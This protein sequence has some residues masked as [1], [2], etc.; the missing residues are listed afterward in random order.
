[1]LQVIQNYK[2]GK[3]TVDEVPDPVL[4]PGGIIVRNHFSL[5]S[6]GT[7]RTT[8][9]TAQK[10]LAGKAKSR[11]DLVKQVVGVARRDGVASTIKLVKNKLDTSVPMGYSCAGEVIAVATD[12]DE[13]AIGDMVA[14]AGQGYASHAEIIYVPRNLAA[15]IPNGVKAE[16]AA[17]TT[18]GAIAMQSVR[19]AEIVLGEHVAVIGLGLLGLLTAQ[20]LKA[21]SCKVLGIDIKPEACTLARKLGVEHTVSSDSDLVPFVEKATH[22]FGVDKVII[23]AASSNNEPILTAGSIVREK[24]KVVI[25]GG[26]PADIPRSPFYEKEVDICFSRSYGPGRYDSTYEERGIDYPYGYVRWTENRNMQTFLDLLADGKIKFDKIITHKFQIG[27]AKEAYDMIT[28]KSKAKENYIGILLKYDSSRRK[29][30]IVKTSTPRSKSEGA[31]AVGFIGAGNFA[32][33]YLLPAVQANKDANLLGVATSR[34]VT[35]KNVAEKFGFEFAASGAEEILNNAETDAVFIATRHNLHAPYVIDALEKNKAVYVEKP[36]A[37]NPEQLQD[38]LKAHKKFPGCVMVGFNRRFSELTHQT[39]HFLN[40][41]LEP[42]FINYRIN[43]GLVSQEHWI[44]DPHE[45]G[46][47]IIGEVCH[48]VDFC[49]FIVTS[50]PIRVFAD[51]ITHLKHDFTSKDNVSIIIKYRDGSIANINYIASGDKSLPKERIEIACEG[52]SVVIDDFQQ[53]QFHRD[54]RMK[55]EQTSKAGQRVSAECK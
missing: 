54:N 42:C 38:V 3:L 43:A 13:F 23:C 49:N 55:K 21:S 9:S 53:I 50:L 20:I 47:R 37:L 33:N 7:E 39:R 18:L 35:A 44:Q 34:G 31:V 46:G 5:I 16:D 36:L 29:T 11:P 45:G 52:S 22:N 2:T 17:F 4:K 15:K 1:M 26:V 8:V 14:C 10:S 25:V 48:F 19:Q 28:G 51:V 41:R 27:D 40:K 24:G 32:Q 30:P 12:V 6:A